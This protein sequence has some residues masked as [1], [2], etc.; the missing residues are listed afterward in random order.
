MSKYVIVEKRQQTAV[1][2]E[3]N[4]LSSLN[5]PFILKVY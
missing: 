3:K 4:I 5:H 2:K 1:V